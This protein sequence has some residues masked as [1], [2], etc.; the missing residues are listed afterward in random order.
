[1]GTHQAG[2]IVGGPVERKDLAEARTADREV[3]SGAGLR[4]EYRNLPAFERRSPA[5]HRGA[6]TLTQLRARL[7]VGELW[8]ADPYRHRS[9]VPLVAV[10]VQ[11]KPYRVVALRDA[12]KPWMARPDGRRRS[13]GRLAAGKNAGTGPDHRTLAARSA[14]RPRP[15][16]AI[17][18]VGHL[19]WFERR[20]RHRLRH[21]SHRQ[22]HRAHDRSCGTW[23]GRMCDERRELICDDGRV[24]HTDPCARTERPLGRQPRH[25][26][27]VVR[28]ADRY[29]D[30]GL[31]RGDQR[32][33]HGG[34]PAR[35]FPGSEL[36]MAPDMVRDR[37]RDRVRSRSFV[38]AG[39]PQQSRSQR[40]VAGRRRKQP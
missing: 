31:Q 21:R 11:A 16:R 19:D 40:D 8:A 36:G 14:D 12:Q 35:R 28:A 22:P 1:M 32:R 2:E 5:L 25:R 33:V 29:G 18:S 24:D 20:T 26:R 6:E 27:T 3:P 7:R 30:G 9:N 17:E 39:R 34:V 37:I 4:L 15:I 10:T 23:S 13:D 38:V